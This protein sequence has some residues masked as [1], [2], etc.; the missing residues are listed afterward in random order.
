VRRQRDQKALAKTWDRNEEQDCFEGCDGVSHEKELST[1]LV[2][3][4]QNTANVD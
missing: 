1:V 4:N 2:K 3:L